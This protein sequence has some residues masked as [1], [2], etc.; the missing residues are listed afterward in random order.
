MCH[1]VAAANRGGDS[2]EG[3]R[4][5]MGKEWPEAASNRARGR[6]GWKGNPWGC[7]LASRVGNHVVLP[8]RRAGEAAVIGG[9]GWPDT[10]ATGCGREAWATDRWVEQAKRVTGW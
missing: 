8:R 2:V 7:M 1:A 3:G 4:R 5:S 9:M 6:T 10:W